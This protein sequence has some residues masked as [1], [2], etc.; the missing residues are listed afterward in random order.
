MVLSYVNFLPGEPPLLPS[1]AIKAGER[2]NQWRSFKS[3][4]PKEATGRSMT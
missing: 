2:L 1:G 4:I 3:L